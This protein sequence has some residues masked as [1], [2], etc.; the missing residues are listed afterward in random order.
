MFFYGMSR[1]LTKISKKQLVPA[2]VLFMNRLAVLE[3]SLKIFFDKKRLKI[4]R[5]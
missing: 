5:N 2:R 4:C 3:T 1:A